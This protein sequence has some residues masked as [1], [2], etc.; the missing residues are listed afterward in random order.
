MSCEWVPCGWTKFLYYGFCCCCCGLV[1]LMLNWWLI[2]RLD[3]ASFSS[4][5][6][7][8]TIA[9]SSKELIVISFVALFGNKISRGTNIDILNRVKFLKSHLI[10]LDKEL[11]FFKRK[12]IFPSLKIDNYNI[13]FM[14]YKK[15]A[16][17]IDH[18]W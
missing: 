2:D 18:W 14:N 17:T 4:T 1:K 9:W 5:T 16:L 11:S 12:K 15:C 10:I 3:L 13:K 8:R 7:K 6:M